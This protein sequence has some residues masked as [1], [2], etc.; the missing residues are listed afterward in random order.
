MPIDH[1]PA[2]WRPGAERLRAWMLTDASLL[3]ILGGVFIARGIGFMPPPG[4]DIHP[5][6]VTSPLMWGVIWT[7]V[8]AAALIAAPWHAD[9][10]GAAILGV[11]TGLLVFWGLAFALIDVDEFLTRGTIYLGWASVILWAVWRG[12][13][14]EITVRHQVRGES[15]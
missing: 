15:R 2:R 6:E 14:G 8:G 12:R 10:I 4:D 13:R 7:G 1:V 11:A 3:L 5:W 9:R